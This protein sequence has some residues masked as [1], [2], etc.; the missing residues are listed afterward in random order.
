MVYINIICKCMTFLDD[1]SLNLI[2]DSR[3]RVRSRLEF[4]R[5]VESKAFSLEWLRIRQSTCIANLSRNKRK[6]AWD[7]KT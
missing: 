7:V 2:E 5:H 6:I 1:M 4:W 3:E